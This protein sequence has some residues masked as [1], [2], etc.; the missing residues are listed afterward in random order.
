MSNFFAI[1]PWQHCRSL[2]SKTHKQNSY[3]I[4]W[5]GIFLIANKIA[6]GCEP[7]LMNE[8]TVMPLD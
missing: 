2:A 7:R 1:K 6:C 4:L 5:L 3:R 8:T